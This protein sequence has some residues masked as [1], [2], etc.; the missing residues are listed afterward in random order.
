M[1]AM[2]LIDLARYVAALLFV[3]ALIGFAWIAARRYGLPGVVSGQSTRRL[4][5]VE[6]LMIGPRH[7]LM[8]LRRDGTEHL[9]MMGPQGAT[10]IETG[11]RERPAHAAIAMLKVAE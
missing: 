8:L 2:D 4:G 3:L 9:V 1:H 5:V 6:T 10:I 11:V 7:K